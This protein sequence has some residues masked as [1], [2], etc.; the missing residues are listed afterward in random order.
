LGKAYTYLSVLMTESKG[1]PTEGDVMDLISNAF[2]MEGRGL[3]ADLFRDLTMAIRRA[4]PE[5]FKLKV[6]QDVFVQA[7]KSAG[8]HTKTV[9]PVDMTFSRLRAEFVADTESK[10]DFTRIFNYAEREWTA[11]IT[12]RI[13]PFVHEQMGPHPELVYFIDV[14]LPNDGYM[15]SRE[16]AADGEYGDGVALNEGH[17]EAAAFSNL[18]ADT[19]VSFQAPDFD[20]TDVTATYN[21][22]RKRLAFSFFDAK[23]RKCY[24]VQYE[25]GYHNAA[26]RYEGDH[27]QAHAQFAA[28]LIAKWKK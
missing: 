17:A 12:H 11:T 21:G 19:L 3:Y 14:R 23:N 4:S 1:D 9:K 28:L 10:A 16:Y 13:A 24:T 20:P 8:L 22:A 6:L 27:A 15:Y 18:V 5:K 2:N 7:I 25:Y 26:P